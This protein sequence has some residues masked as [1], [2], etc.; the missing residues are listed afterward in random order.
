[1]HGASAEQMDVEVSDSLPA[2]CACINDRSITS[3]EIVFR[4]ELC[5]NRMQV[6]EQRCIGPA[7]LC[8]G[9]NVLLGHDQY[10]HGRLRIYVSKYIGE[11]ILVD[12]F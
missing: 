1:M 2:I 4:S 6:A 9:C 12:F 5:C 11:V 3:A 7:G 10:M 8:E